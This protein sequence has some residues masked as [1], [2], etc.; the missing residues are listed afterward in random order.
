MKGFKMIYRKCFTL[1]ELL[2][3][4][5]IIAILAAM[6]LPVLNKA[7][8]SSKSISCLGNIKQFGGAA[9]F[10]ANDHNDYFLT[11]DNSWS[12]DRALNLYFRYLGG[13]AS[14]SNIGSLKVGFCPADSSASRK[15]GIPS[16]R[17]FDCTWSAWADNEGI[18]YSPF[19]QSLQSWALNPAY[20]DSR[21]NVRTEKLSKLSAYPNYA[22]DLRFKLALFADDPVLP[23]H[24]SG[25]SSF[26]INAARADGSAKSC[27]I[28]LWKPN[29][30][31]IDDWLI[32]LEGRTG[33]SLQAFMEASNPQ[34]NP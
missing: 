16:Y 15:M 13:D 4:I 18:G 23:N 25:E 24:Y 12:G 14:G 7:R 22:R 34:L 11:S 32:R 9:V 8:A 2:V 31:S 6:L 26:H 3:V 17:A 5:A 30:L 10:Y 33:H 19:A 29:P 21:A 27:R 20:P 1:I 28:T